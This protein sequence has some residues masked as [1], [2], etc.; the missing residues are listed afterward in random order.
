MTAKLEV[1]VIAVV[2]NGVDMVDIVVVV[3]S[4]IAALSDTDIDD[5]G[6]CVIVAPADV[7]EGFDVTDIRNVGVVVGKLVEEVETIDVAEA[8]VK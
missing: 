2:I 5:A 6:P 4:A 7:Y 1:G 8:K 3:C